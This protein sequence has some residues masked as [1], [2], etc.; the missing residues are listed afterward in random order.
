MLDELREYCDVHAFADGAP[1]RR[2]RR[3]ARRARPTA[4][5]CSPCGS[6]VD[7]ERAR[8]AATTASSTASAT[9]SSTRGALA[10]LRRRSGVV[11][12]HEVRLTD[13]YALE[14]RR[15]GR[16][17]GRLRGLP[18]GDVRR[19]AARNRSSGR[20]TA[21]EAERFG[22][23]MAAE[24]VGARRPLRRDVAVR[25]RPRRASTSIPSYAD[26]IVVAAVRRAATWSRTR[27]PSAERGPIVASFGI[28]NDIKQNSVPIAALP[29]VLARCPEASLA[30]VG[31][32]ADAD[33]EQLSE[34]AE[35]SACPTM[36]SSPARSADA[37]YAAWLDRA[38]VA[39]QLRRSANGESF[40]DGRRLPRVGRGADR[41]RHRRRPRPAR[42]RRDQ[43]GPGGDGRRELA[44]IVAD[45]ARRSRAPA[46]A[47]GRGRAY[48]AAHSHAVVARR[49]FEDVIEPATHAGLTAPRFG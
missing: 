18:P 19:I 2:L 37:E 38:A 45:L 12:A 8:A 33:R 36:W 23:L 22:V 24:V 6:S 7:H 20:L 17:A 35:A 30:F 26:R 48:A 15:A 49:L 27:R 21:D 4:S 47:R 40:G 41:H 32:C 28:V 13:L 11:L 43:R 39:V 46:S 29:A 1:A 10:Q 31:P 9:A 5:R 3:S 25:R 14:R 42:R 16:G 44:T 34:L